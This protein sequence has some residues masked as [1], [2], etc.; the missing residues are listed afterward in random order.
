MLNFVAIRKGINTAP[1][2]SA[3]R[4]LYFRY[5]SM[6]HALISD[7][8]FIRFC[9]SVTLRNCILS[10][11][12][13]NLGKLTPNFLLGMLIQGGSYIVFP[14]QYLKGIRLFKGAGLFQ[15]LKKLNL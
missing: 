9:C 13:Q 8:T 3:A 7:G 12:L 10:L 6:G 15:R 2:T 14:N 11:S 1:G 5:F 4:I